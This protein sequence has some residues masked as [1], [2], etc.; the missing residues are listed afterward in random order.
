MGYSVQP[1]CLC[2]ALV[3]IK[4]KLKPI[5]AFRLGELALLYASQGFERFP[6]G[7]QLGIDV[8]ELR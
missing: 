1:V 5:H 4:P 6:Y 7:L 8:V 3:F 2:L